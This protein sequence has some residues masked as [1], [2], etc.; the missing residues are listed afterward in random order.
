MDI[1]T[2]TQTHEKGLKE[3]TIE[4]KKMHK[5]AEEEEMVKKDKEE[6]HR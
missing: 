4:I 2:H 3:N 5:C 1:H 6:S